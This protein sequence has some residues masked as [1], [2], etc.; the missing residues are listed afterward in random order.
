MSRSSCPY[1]QHAIEW[2]G[3]ASATCPGCRRPVRAYEPNGGTVEAW[4]P[5]EIGGCRLLEPAGFRAGGHVYKA[6]DASGKEL[7][8]VRIFPGFG[9]LSPDTR[10]EVDRELSLLAGVEQDN[11]VRVKSQG[12]EAG[13]RYLVREWVVGAPLNEALRSARGDDRTLP[14]ATVLPIFQKLAAALKALHER[15]IAHGRIRPE[16]VLVGENNEVTLLEPEVLPNSS[17]RD[18]YLAPERREQPRA[19]S[20]SDIYELGMVLYEQLTGFL[21]GSV[22]RRPSIINSTVP[23]WFDKLILQMLE[24]DP[25]ARPVDLPVA[26]GENA[27]LS[28]ETI[29]KL[30]GAIGGAILGGGIGALSA[31]LWNLSPGEVWLGG[32]CGLILGLLVG[33]V[34]QPGTGGTGQQRRRPMDA[35]PTP[36]QESESRQGTAQRDGIRERGN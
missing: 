16:Q 2:L 28:E 4:L 21:P 35:G 36:Q 30:S 19:T 31:Y 27:G 18:V 1:C 12:T 7:V 8:A 5:G 14:F 20:R 11:L 24:R 3:D 32:L 17:E 25:Q 15:R 33:F 26:V 23:P 34:L 22:P 13:V 9:R 10:S 29:N 6:Q